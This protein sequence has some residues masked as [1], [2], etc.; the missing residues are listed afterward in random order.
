MR[1]LRLIVTDTDFVTPAYV[2][3]IVAKA[4]F[5]VFV[6]D[7]GKLADVAPAATTTLAGRLATL[8]AELDSA[9]VAPP[10][11]AGAVSVT[12]PS[13]DVPATM[14][15]L[16]SARLASAGA[17]GVTVNVVVFVTPA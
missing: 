6:V 16:L 17:A 8:G 10:L 9:T 3:E 11:G 14:L 15:V 2:A 13:A 5:C 12:V 4:F 1:Y 7:T